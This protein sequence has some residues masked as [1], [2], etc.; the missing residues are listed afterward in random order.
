MSILNKLAVGVMTVGAVALVAKFVEIHKV[1]KR[2]HG[3]LNRYEQEAK[4][5][6]NRITGTLMF[7]DDKIYMVN[8]LIGR[9]KREYSLAGFDKEGEVFFE[10]QRVLLMAMI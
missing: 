1:Y 6:E 7:R 2:A 5:V 3:I 9:Y 10:R 8:E 4:H